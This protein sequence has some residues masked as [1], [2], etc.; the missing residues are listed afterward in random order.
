MN[1][2][3]LRLFCAVAEAGTLSGA[4]RKLNLNHSTVYRRINALEQTHSVRLFER[5]DRG[6]LL[7]AEGEEMWQVTRRL[8]TEVDALERKLSGRDLR[9]SGTVRVTTTDTLINGLLGP[10]LADFKSLYPGIQLEIVLDTQHLNLSKRQADIAIRPTNQPPDTLVGRRI[11]DLGFAIYGSEPYLARSADRQNL[12][13]HSWI[14]PDESLSHLGAHRWVSANLD[15]PQVAMTS[16]NLFGLLAGALNHMGLAPLPC[17]MGD[18]QP[19]LVRLQTLDQ[20]TSLWILTHADLRRSARIRAF[21][22]FMYAALLSQRR[23]LEG[24]YKNP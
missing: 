20:P 23:I 2:D 17:F 12:S 21:M 5:L 15:M 18:Q 1:W 11:S 16:N 14:L 7:T 22:D 19:T 8:S 13:A 6:Y 4:A 24:R 9:L 10:H 3:D